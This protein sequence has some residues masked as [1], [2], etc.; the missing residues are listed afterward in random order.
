MLL[1][2]LFSAAATRRHIVPPIPQD[3]PSTR[4]A[5]SKLIAALVAALGL[6]AAALAA[7]IRRRKLRRLYRLDDI[8]DDDRIEQQAT[9]IARGADF[10]AIGAVVG[11]TAVALGAVALDVAARQIDRL[12]QFADLRAI[13]PGAQRAALDLAQTHAGEMVTGIS[14]TTRDMIRAAIV[15]GLADGQ[16]TDQIADAIATDS[17]FSPERAALIA[18]TEISSI[19]N[20]AALSAMKLARDK[21]NL[22]LKKIWLV[23]GDPCDECADCADEIAD[24]DDDFSCGADS[25]PLHPNCMCQLGSTL[26]GDD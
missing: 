19:S 15:R 22:P 6:T 17:A 25:P 9:E 18:R 16:T 12:N 10:S 1:D 14:E 13:V 20:S 7:E 21:G 3:R 26:G 23:D 11:V 8:D 2:Q 5:T 4:L 24:L